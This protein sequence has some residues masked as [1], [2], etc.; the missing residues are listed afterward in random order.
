M[1]GEVGVVEVYFFKGYGDGLVGG[2]EVAVAV[3]DTD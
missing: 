3:E 1:V 2:E